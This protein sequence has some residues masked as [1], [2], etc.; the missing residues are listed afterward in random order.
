M[1]KYLL[2]R[3]KNR[4]LVQICGTDSFRFLQ[5]L[6]TN[7][8][9][10]IIT[11]K[12]FS[13]YKNIPK[14]VLSSLDGTNS[15]QLCG[16]NVNHK[17]WTKGLPSL[18]LQ[19]NGKILA[20]CFL[21]NVKYTNEEN[22]FS[23]FYMDCNM[24]A[25][26]MLLS[27]LEKRKLSCDVHFSQMTNIAVYQLLSCPPVLR[28][29]ISNIDTIN[30]GGDSATKM[31]GELSTLSND[32][33]IFF[34][35]KDARNDLL[36]YRMYQIRGKEEELVDEK[37]DKGIGIIMTT[38]FVNS[39]CSKTPEGEMDEFSNGDM[40]E[41]CKLLLSF[42]KEEKVNLPATF[43]YD[44][45]KL[46][47]GVVE[48]LYSNDSLL[49]RNRQGSTS[50]SPCS[51]VHGGPNV[52]NATNVAKGKIDRDAFKF[53]DLSPFDLNYDKLN[54]LA[55]DKGCY[56]GQEA[57][58]RTRNE[59]FINKY[60]LT[61]CVN[62]DYLEMFLHNCDSLNKTI[63]ADSFFHKYVK[64]INNKSSFKP[65]FFLLKNASKSLEPSIN[66]EQ[67]FNVIVQEDSAKGGDSADRKDSENGTIVGN[68][69][70]YN[71]VMGLCFLIKKR[72]A[73]VSADIY[74]PTS[75]VYIKK[76]VGEEHHRVCLFP[77]NYPTKA[78]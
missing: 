30:S 49:G 43:V 8:L 44:Y 47:L 36:G 14:N 4:T 5:S 9:N 72:I 73:H 17:K 51:S 10:K 1:N 32:P 16:H 12:D 18:F 54:Y 37:K 57:I 78:F 70:F 31:E 69:F 62:Y 48:N 76:K 26:R 20:D 13:L 67:Q 3:L 2:C 77:F 68:V 63:L 40:K 53:K 45:M 15:Y 23:L 28:G 41:T 50:D 11:E 24:D 71:H 29:G 22:T 19:N 52:S 66:Y 38:D 58:N 56:V 25:S 39:S 35:S 7:D 59:I 27:L 33:G 21:Y 65:T 6:T 61:M 46:N 75:N 60:Q 74:S 42:E 34:L 64:Q 55:K